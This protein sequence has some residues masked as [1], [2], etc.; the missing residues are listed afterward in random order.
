MT[1]DI[2]ATRED[3][4]DKLA[5]TKYIMVARNGTAAGVVPG[6][7]LANQEV[8]LAFSILYLILLAGETEVLSD[9]AL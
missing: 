8:I 9:V 3:G 1:I 6:L 5:E 2:I 4:E 7:L